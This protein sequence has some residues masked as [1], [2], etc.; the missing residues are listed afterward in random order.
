MKTELDMMKRDGALYP[1]SQV[2]KDAFDRITS[3]RKVIVTVHQARNPD[4]HAK[5]WAVATKVADNDPHFQDAED[6]MEWAKLKTP[7]MIRSWKTDG[8]KIIVQTKSIS[9]ASMDQLRFNEFYDRAVKLWSERLG[10][11]VETLER[12]A[13][14]A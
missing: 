12:E 2:A 10:V 14:A 5:A 11:D 7:W 13:Q 9:Y 4:H 1:S 6:A 3:K 8:D